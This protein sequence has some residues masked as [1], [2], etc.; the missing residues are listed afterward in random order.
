M[1]GSDGVTDEQRAD[2]WLKVIGQYGDPVRMTTVNW[3]AANVLNHF[4]GVD[5]RESIAKPHSVILHALRTL[6][7]AANEEIDSQLEKLWELYTDI[8]KFGTYVPKIASTSL[9]D[10]GSGNGYLGG[11]LSSLGVHYTGVEPSA[12]LHQA[13][14]RDERLSSATLVQSTI[15]D[16][17][18]NSSFEQP[19]APTLISIIGVADLVADPGS[20]MRTLADFLA[21]QHW[22]NVPILVA[23]F[24]P[25]FFLP[26]L[27]IS[28][29]V[30]QQSN[31]YGVDEAFR[32][33]DPAV[34]EVIF[35]NAGFHLLEQRPLHLASLPVAISDYLIRLHERLFPAVDSIAE[36]EGYSLHK[37]MCVPP[38][39]G[40]FYFW[41]ICSRNAVI[42]RHTE[43]TADS[44]SAALHPKPSHLEIFDQ[45]EVLSVL[46]NLGANVYKVIKGSAY[47]ESPETGLMPFYEGSLFGQLEASYNYVSSRVVGN[48]IAEKGAILEVTNSLDILRY[49]SESSHFCD[50]LFLSLLHH[51]DSVQFHSFYDVKRV[52]KGE[53]HSSVL[54]RTNLNHEPIL[55]LLKNVRNIAACLLQQS[56]NSVPGALEESYRSRIFFELSSD[57]LGKLIYGP[58]CNREYEDLY[59]IMADLVQANVIDNFSPFSLGRNSVQ[60]SISTIEHNAD[61]ELDVILLNPL[62]FGWQAARFVFH[63]FSQPSE[64]DTD[65]TLSTLALSISAFFRH[66]ADEEAFKQYI[67]ESK[68]LGYKISSFTQSEEPRSKC[69]RDFILKQVDGSHKDLERLDNFLVKLYDGFCVSDRNKN[70]TT[71][72]CLSNFFVVRD[73]WALMG[74][75]LNDK[76]IWNTQNL[77]FE[78]TARFITEHQQRSRIIAY[79]Q[80]CIKNVGNQAGLDGTPW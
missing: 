61:P 18:N 39:Q 35:A 12:A 78:P 45:A 1:D 6:P 27:P 74:C 79:A 4:G 22:A 76:S 30:L 8:A 49:L 33:K 16:F 62:N 73:I 65:A 29:D 71:Q 13:A 47:Y 40:P 63:H 75:L 57:A 68:H 46:G 23:T 64:L 52:R 59:P 9:L 38:R 10:L 55:Y 60:E 25:D 69:F 5:R 7:V 58:S 67:R 2:A 54:I 28:G 51:L 53:E 72:Y 19:D 44:P 70:Y 11:W 34:W 80:E 15:E 50:A 37:R 42:K 77:K 21:S 31:H 14:Q 48:L 43:L 41:L 66:K 32:I 20:T 26:G 3:I 24:D 17:C 56:A 36:T